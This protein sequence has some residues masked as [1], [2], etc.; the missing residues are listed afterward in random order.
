[1][2]PIT[3]EA[4]PPIKPTFSQDTKTAA[5]ALEIVTTVLAET[6]GGVLAL[7]ANTV[8]ASV[9]SWI[10]IGIS[11]SRGALATAFAALGFTKDII[12]IARRG[13]AALLAA[14]LAPEL[15]PIAIAVVT[16]TGFGLLLDRVANHPP[17]PN[18]A[19]LVTLSGL[20]LDVP[21]TTDPVGDVALGVAD[22][23]LAAGDA[24]AAALT[25]AERY[26]GAF[27]AG[28]AELAA[29]H[30]ARFLDFQRQ[31][32]LLLV[33]VSEALDAFGEAFE[34]RFGV[35]QLTLQ[36]VSDLRAQLA[37]AGLPLGL[38]EIFN[39]PTLEFI[40]LDLDA[41]RQAVAELSPDLF[42]LVGGPNPF[43]ET[44]IALADF[45]NALASA[46]VPA[47]A[48]FALLSLGFLLLV[49]ARR[50]SAR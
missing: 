5:Q 29:S 22:A 1:L 25:S 12:T 36:Q 47:P 17:D 10:S 7:L 30:Y 11:I 24:L 14:G 44:G 28:D 42:S 23:V 38:D 18:Y 6:L 26:E 9:M 49:V 40:D 34:A 45:R 19:Q 50:R 32:S 15:I 37:A 20:T 43:V 3:V 35:A 21:P 31:A 41:T 16:L 13:A 33:E 4:A 46:S 39:D 48:T 8:A 2:N 27:A